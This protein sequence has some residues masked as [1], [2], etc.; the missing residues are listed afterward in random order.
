MKYFLP[1]LLLLF[2]LAVFLRVDFFFTIAYLFAAIYILSRWWMARLA[3]NL[4]LQRHFL[5]RAFY[6]D[7]VSVKVTVQNNGWLPAP[8][9]EVR[10]SLP[11]ELA[12]PPMYQQVFGL[13]AHQTHHFN[14]QLQCRRRGYH[15]LGTLQAQL[16]D[17]LGLVPQN[18]IHAPE[19]LI[20]YPRIVPLAKLGLPTRSPLAI[21]KTPTPLFEDTS[22]VVGVREY[23]R[24]D[25]PRKIHWTASAS[26]NQLLVK[27]YQPAIARETMIALDLNYESYAM[28]GRYEAVEMAITAAASVATHIVNRQRLPTGLFTEARDALTKKTE[29]FFLPARAENAHLSQILESLARVHLTDRPSPFNTVLRRESVNLA[30]GTT[31][32]AITGHADE[33]LLQTLASLKRTGFAVAL[34]V[35]QYERLETSLRAQGQALGINIYQVWHDEE[36]VL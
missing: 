6:G 36:L 22:R 23:Q 24:G 11:L 32:L 10:E 33:S 17:L 18:L 21:L 27:Q 34:I 31:V 19:Y 25:S 13:R 16:G 9:V 8:Y 35:I 5:P 4:H 7:E 14:Y 12:T 2:A 28:R 20:V 15:L 3:K 29:R 30:W 1:Y 26:A